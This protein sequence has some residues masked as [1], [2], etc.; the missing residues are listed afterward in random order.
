MTDEQEEQLIKLAS[1]FEK[2]YQA[3]EAAIAAVEATSREKSRT[4]GLLFKALAK[5]ALQG[6]GYIYFRDHST[7]GRIVRVKSLD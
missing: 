2:A 4:E 5:G 1:D 6:K 3:H 7:S